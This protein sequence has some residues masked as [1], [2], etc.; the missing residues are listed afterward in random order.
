M[1]KG[2]TFVSQDSE[3]RA[4][5]K[6]W[7][8]S[9]V[10]LS[11]GSRLI[12]FK[13]PKTSS[14]LIDSPSP[15]EI[16]E[17]LQTSRLLTFYGDPT[18]EIDETQAD[19]SD[20]DAVVDG[21]LSAEGVDRVRDETAPAALPHGILHSPRPDKEIGPVLRNLMRKSKAEYLDRG[22]SVLYLAFGMLDWTDV[23]DQKMASPLLLV[24]VTLVPEGPKGKPRLQA[25]DDESVINPALALR[26]KEFNIALPTADGFDG[27]AVSEVLA[28]VQAT[29]EA[30]PAFKNWEIRD[31]TYLSTFTFTKEAMYRDLEDNE[32]RIL[33]HPIVRAL[34]TS[35]PSQQSPEFQFDAIDDVDIDD[36]APPEQAHLVLDADSSQRAA[37]AAALAGK[38]FVMDG[39]P[40]TGKS[41]TIANMIG[42][43][44]HAGKRVLFVSEKIA[45]L[46][47]VRNRLV[48]AGLGSYVLE[49]HSHKASRK[50]VAAELLRTL[51]TVVV[52]PEGM[53]DLTRAKV[54]EARERLTAYA[55]AMNKVRQT[56]NMSLHDVLG[57]L[58][59]LSDA[60]S[61]PVSDT[62]T[63]LLS[64]AE[65][66]SILDTAGTLARAWR[67]AQQGLSFLWRDVVDEDSMDIR[68]Y[69]ALDAL[70]ELR[71]TA[72]LS[73]AAMDAFGLRAPSDA[74]ALAD[75]I[76]LWNDRRSEAALDEWLTAEWREFV[77]ITNER[78]RLGQLLDAIENG[79]RAFL[80]A[81]GSPWTAIDAA[82]EIPPPPSPVVLHPAAIDM[83]GLRANELRSLASYFGGFA[84]GLAERKDA[85]NQLALALGLGE[86]TRYSDVDKVVRAVELR[87]RGAVPE[88]RWFTP[89]GLAEARAAA[90]R[91]RGLV[92]ALADAEATASRTF[93]PDALRAPLADLNDRFVNVHKG[94][95]K[96][97]AAYRKDR[98]D[99]SEI[100]IDS[101]LVKEGIERLPD[102]VLWGEA[103]AAYK[104]GARADTELLG[105][106]WQGRETN[107]DALAAALD[108]V[109]DAILLTDGAVPGP[110]VIYLRSGQTADPYAA[111]VAE[112][113]RYIKS[114]VSGAAPTPV[115][116]G[117]TELLMRS[118]DEGISW[119]LAQVRPLTLAAERVAAVD[120]AVG[121]DRPVR[122]A[123][124]VLA[125]HA[126]VAAAHASLTGRSDTFRKAFGEHFAGT[127]TDLAALDTALAWATEMRELAHCQLDPERIRALN[128]ASGSEALQLSFDRWAAVS[129]RVATAFGADRCEEIRG[130]LDNYDAADDLLN[131]FRAD[132]IGQQEWFEYQRAR[133]ELAQY[134]LEPAVEYCIK[135]RINA[136]DVVGVLEKAILR[137]WA[138][139]I[140][141]RDRALRP[142]LWTDREALVEEYRSLDRQLIANATS[143]IIAAAN[144]RRPVNTSI[145]EPAVI[146]REG[147]KQRRHIPVR[148]LI[149]KSYTTTTAIKPVFMMSPLAVSQYLPSN[150]TFDVVIFDE[151]SQVTP[152][153][154]VNCIYRGESLVLAGDDKQLPPTSFFERVTEDDED[155]DTDVTDFQSILEL[156]KASGA[157]NDLGLRWHYRSRHEDLVAFSNYK[158]YEGK[159]ITYP[160]AHAEG[161]DVGIEFFDAHGI[162][163]RGG[164]AYNPIEAKKVA[165]R[166]IEHFTT[167]P[168]LSVGVVTFSV[169]QADA[170]VDALD[171]A[172]QHRRDLDRFFDTDDRLGGFFVRSLESVQ[173]DERDV[174]IFSVGYGPDEAGKVSTN[175]GVLNK[176]KGW[177]RLNVGITRARQRVEVVASMH[178]GDIPPSSNENVEYLRAYMDYAERG[179]QSLATVTGPTGLG[180]DSPFEESVIA[181]LRNWGYDVEPQVG[182]AGFRIDI[183][184]RH[185]DH[186]GTFAIGVECDGYQYHSAPAARDRDRL[187]E[188]VLT[189]LGWRLHRIW[190]TAWYRDR[191]AEEA[192]LKQAVDA[193][194]AD[195]VRDSGTA[196]LRIDRPPLE[197]VTVS[198]E[199]APTWTTKYSRAAPVLLPKW[200][201]PSVAGNHHS[202][203]HAI[204]AIAEAEGPVHL[205][206]V[207]DRVR[208][209]WNIGRVGS[210]IRGNIMR[211]I[212]ASGVAF[213]DNFID[214]VD[215]EVDRVRVPSD[216]VSR[217]AEQIHLSELG[218]AAAMLVADVGAAPRA[219]VVRSLARVFGWNRTGGLVEARINAAI[220]V[221]INAGEITEDGGNLRRA[222]RGG[223][224]FQMEESAA[225]KEPMAG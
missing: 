88:A 193:A 2:C 1:G 173:G 132:T 51:D 19:E 148:S 43:L 135:Q 25:R 47:V 192:R 16:L 222:S 180:P 212:S 95:R 7:R 183:G 177:R 27:Q 119:L 110:L 165:E 159:L 130:E 18:L 162:Y 24:P 202:M 191:S 106:H 87:S 104:A 75:L 20:A 65:Y 187:R 30:V 78:S 112:A 216:G 150:M 26:L 136:T 85:L 126:G 77:S 109:E 93:T 89:V 108:V 28:A 189:G 62:S 134:G 50:E 31:S 117:R 169:A 92:D 151:A 6:A 153:D 56:L 116:A 14:I 13:A 81:T 114:W 60:P 220:D 38:T 32:E 147:A 74:P 167:R 120:A 63:A 204:N 55:E 5:L 44:L 176:D 127:A 178:A 206:F 133:G 10:G 64:E 35:D 203:I 39:P 98:A 223:R 175:F 195:D 166:V 182:A 40:G 194:I 84:E 111:A 105:A 9:L 188:Q 113:D 205:D 36:A 196:V 79:E 225:M 99:V 145:G 80:D 171:E 121:G 71:G 48:E 97:T 214:V 123:E 198:P 49:L 102:A 137:G 12:K 143:E 67:P 207:F 217:T 42:A 197:T 23:D 21:V 4:A 155:P 125:L 168:D 174:I 146:R 179:Q 91:M 66:L 115:I 213:E 54:R 138:A 52:P 29:I 57:K 199:Q 170:V 37:I 156:A 211:A 224:I 82:G 181:V 154:A 141:D 68:V 90:R 185:P 163:R 157:F 11:R 160:S 101:A 131:A 83:D 158:F 34:G 46:E 70:E 107:F 144:A 3:I 61:A 96:L 190:G 100:L 8:E 172:R 17:R 208:D 122:E 76:R 58:S 128:S 103:D 184:I 152:G 201:D 215:R 209:W 210:I 129:G 200:A 94:L 118:I 73:S 142:L 59:M 139:S 140:T 86:V 72:E 15:D 149:A 164:G 45:A 221:A 41:Q 69:Q 22:L 53:R 218:L 124:E 219:E 186:P 33:A 161:N